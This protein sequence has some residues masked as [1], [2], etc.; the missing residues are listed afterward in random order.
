MVPEPVT[1]QERGVRSRRM[2]TLARILRNWAIVLALSLGSIVMLFPLFW[3]LITSVKTP[4]QIQRVPLEFWPNP[5]DWSS[6]PNAWGDA[7]FSLYTKNSLIV[8]VGATATCVFVSS[9][10]AY[11]LARLEFKGKNLVFLLI[12]STMMIPGQIT[13]IPRFLISSR[14]PLAGHN[15]LLGQGGS[16]LLNTYVG[17]MVPSLVTAFGVF[18]MRQF[19]LGFP[20]DLEDAGRMDG[21]SE[22]MIYWRLVLPMCVPALV[23]LAMLTFTGVWNDFL[24]P[25][26]MTTSGNMK[27]IPL[28]LMA[29]RGVFFTDWNGVMAGTAISIAPTIALFVV[30]QRYFQRSLTLTGMGGT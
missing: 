12:L 7:G 3:M 21:A 28:G 15:N 2:A 19:M 29:L 23:T 16:G 5:V 4:P 24:W 18:L 10:M 11:A 20:R 14:L 8:A 22:F 26:V 27:T 9:L 25:L 1:W 13:F 30:G 17:F 6:Y